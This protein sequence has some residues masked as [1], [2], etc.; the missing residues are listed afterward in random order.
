MPRKKRKAAKRKTKRKVPT[1]AKNRSP[2]VGGTPLKRSPVSVT[3]LQN[4]A[5]LGGLLEVEGAGK[6]FSFTKEK[7]SL[8]YNPETKSLLWIQGVKPSRRK[9]S[10]PDGP[11]AKAYKRWTNH[12]R[13][14]LFER[15]AD[16]PDSVFKK[17]VRIGN[18][19]SIAYRSDKFGSRGEKKDYEHKFGNGVGLY[20][21]GNP[22]GPN[23]WLVRGGKMRV[24]ERGIVG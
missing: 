1:K 15:E 2:A 11:A 23:V 10:N 24:T 17:V 19:Q 8:L 16:V 6:R 13:N 18:A 4:N 14:A 21:F 5:D 3:R 7:P 9:K 12:R 22:S 20:R